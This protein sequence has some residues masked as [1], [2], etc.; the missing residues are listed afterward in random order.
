MIFF[1]FYTF[2]KKFKTTSQFI[3]FLDLIRVLL[4]ISYFIWNNL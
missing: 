2:L 3:I 4:I 1:L